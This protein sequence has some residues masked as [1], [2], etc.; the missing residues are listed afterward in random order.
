MPEEMIKLRNALDARGVQW[1][2]LSSDYGRSFPFEDMTIYKTH[3]GFR[4]R[5]YSVVC[6]FGTFGGDKG[7]LQLTIDNNETV[8]SLTAEN[9]LTIMDK[10]GE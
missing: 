3:F 7:L 1:R 8:G 6:G 5:E 10:G 4:C 2:D 9:I